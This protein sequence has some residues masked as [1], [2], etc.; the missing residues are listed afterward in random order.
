MQKQ[1]SVARKYYKNFTNTDLFPTALNAK[2][3]AVV[4]GHM[5]KSIISRS[6]YLSPGHLLPVCQTFVLSHNGKTEASLCNVFK[7]GG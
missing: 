7:S 6:N 3:G 2:H 4:F 1:K 5:S